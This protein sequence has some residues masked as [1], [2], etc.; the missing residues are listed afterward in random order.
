MHQ[1]KKKKKVKNLFVAQNRQSFLNRK[2]QKGWSLQATEFR[3]LFLNNLS[4]VAL[5]GRSLGGFQCKEDCLFYVINKFFTD[6]LLVMCIFECRF[7]ILI[8]GCRFSGV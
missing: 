2:P 5:P 3:S 1:K 6:S 4:S 8:D 7:E